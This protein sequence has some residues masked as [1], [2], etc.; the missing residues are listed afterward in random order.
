MKALRISTVGDIEVIDIENKLEVIQDLVGGYIEYVDLSQ[1]G[2]DMIINEEGKIYNLD[3][4]LQATLLFRATHLYKDDYIC[5]DVVIVRTENGENIDL[6]DA[7]IT[8]IKVL[9]ANEL[10][11]GEE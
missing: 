10:M 11:K 9:I 7:D 4:N 5:G 3:Y 8:T 6:E 1:D 2:V